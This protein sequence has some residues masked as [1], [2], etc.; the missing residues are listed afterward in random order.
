MILIGNV[1][2]CAVTGHGYEETSLRRLFTSKHQLFTNSND[3]GN[4]RKTLTYNQATDK[5]FDS[6]GRRV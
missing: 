4:Q 6:S 5:P 2:I 1:N 3:A